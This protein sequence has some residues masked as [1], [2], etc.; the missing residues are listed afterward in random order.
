MTMKTPV[1]DRNTNPYPFG[2]TIAHPHA[3]HFTARRRQ[4]KHDIR[5]RIKSVR[6]DIAGSRSVPVEVAPTF[7]ESTPVKDLR[8]AAKAQGITGYSKMAKPALLAALRGA[9]WS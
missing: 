7:S 9:D 3:S 4:M 2:P 1:M 6:R 5:E 8:A